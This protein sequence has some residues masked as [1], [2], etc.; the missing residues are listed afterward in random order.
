MTPDTLDNILPY[1]KAIPRLICL[2][3]ILFQMYIGSRHFSA[4]TRVGLMVD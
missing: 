3:S 2:T 4:I 1:R